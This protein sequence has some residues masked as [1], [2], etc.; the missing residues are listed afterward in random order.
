MTRHKAEKSPDVDSCQNCRFW[1][2]DKEPGTEGRNGKCRP[3]P[4]S[5]VSDG[6]AVFSVWPE[7]ESHE[8]CGSHQRVMQ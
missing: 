5:V 7:T 6:E 3:G 1:L 2:E 4:P 8:W